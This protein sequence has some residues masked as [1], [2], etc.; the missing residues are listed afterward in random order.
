MLDYLP[1]LLLSRLIYERW[2]IVIRRTTGKVAV[3]ELS[4]LLFHLSV[5]VA[6]ACNICYGRFQRGDRFVASLANERDVQVA[7][8]GGN[9]L[10]VDH[11]VDHPVAVWT[12]PA[13]HPDGV[14]GRLAKLRRAARQAVDAAHGPLELPPS[15]AQH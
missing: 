14:A 13:K 4:K 10:W 2:P 8:Y 11:A 7:A 6:S 12:D 9:L 1:T 5:L 3:E 15:R